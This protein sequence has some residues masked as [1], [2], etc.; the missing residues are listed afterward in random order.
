VTLDIYEFNNLKK[1]LKVVNC[2]ANMDWGFHTGC[3]KQVQHHSEM[4][5][6]QQQWF[7]EYLISNMVTTKWKKR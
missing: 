6:L 5:S 2:S 1:L 7:N 3:N 4:A